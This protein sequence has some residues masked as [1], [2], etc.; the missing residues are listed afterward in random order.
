[1]VLSS[2]QQLQ[3]LAG[4]FRIGRFS[5]DSTAAFRDRV[6]TQYNSLGDAYGDVGGLLPGQSGDKFRGR[7]AAADTALGEL[8][9]GVD[10]KRVTRLL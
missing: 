4:M 3:H 8:R 5:Q 1:M 10:L 9:G 7:L 6:T 2:P